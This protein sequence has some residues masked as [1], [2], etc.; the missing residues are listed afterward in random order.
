MANHRM[1]IGK[2]S[3]YHVL[4]VLLLEGKEVFIPVI[5][6]RGVDALVLS[7]MGNGYNEL[8][9]KCR[10]NE[11]RF[12]AIECP[13]PRSNYWFVF[14]IKSINILWLINSIDFDK[15][16]GTIRV[17]GNNTGKRY[18]HLSKNGKFKKYIISDFSQLK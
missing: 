1:R 13:Q 12:T 8:Q 5:D 17:N 11:G 7:S 4:S 9:I 16:A 2:C 3:E 18:I 10:E 15:I 14:Y 6:D